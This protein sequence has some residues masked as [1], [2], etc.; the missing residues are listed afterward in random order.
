M[1]RLIA[2]ALVSALVQVVL[3]ATGQAAGETDQ[4]KANEIYKKAKEFLTT[5]I[6][7]K[8]SSWRN[9]RSGCSLTLRLRS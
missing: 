7:K 1:A 4:V 6:F 9:R 2:L 3:P 8:R 5:M